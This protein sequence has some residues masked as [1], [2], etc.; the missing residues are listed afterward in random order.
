MLSDDCLKHE[1]ESPCSVDFYVHPVYIYICSIPDNE[2]LSP[3]NVANFKQCK[4]I[5]IH[6][7]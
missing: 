5:Y 7:A 4:F 1:T 6:F 3:I 2:H